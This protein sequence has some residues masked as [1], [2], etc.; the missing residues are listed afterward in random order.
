ML[1]DVTFNLKDFRAMLQLCDGLR[2]DICLRFDSAGDPL[3][4][5]PHLAHGDAPVRFH[6]MQRCFLFRCTVAARQLLRLL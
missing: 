3:V 4:V 1:R 5:G 2:A 6:H